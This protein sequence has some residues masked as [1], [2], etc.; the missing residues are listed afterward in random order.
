MEK[1]Q[2]EKMLVDATVRLF[3]FLILGATI[4]IIGGIYL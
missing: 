4:G 1:T 2:R 3:V